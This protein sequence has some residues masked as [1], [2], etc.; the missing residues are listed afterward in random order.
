MKN[1][2]RIFIN[3]ITKEQ[4]I[5]A[6]PNSIEIPFDGECMISQT[7]IYGIITYANR[8]FRSQ[9]GFVKEEIIGMPHSIIRHPDMPDGLYASI[10][11]TI[12]EKK[13]WRGYVKNLCKDGNFYWALLYVQAIV[14][15][16]GEITGYTACR[17]VAYPES[18]EE[19]KVKY[20][21]LKK[22]E[23]FKGGELFHGEELAQKA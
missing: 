23:I 5:Q 3:T 18:I 7:D 14:D 22:G 21:A 16:N 19:A 12:S 4:F 6:E 11:K 2:R 8:E 1:K 15:N 13:I 10:W 17:K 9:N 20:A